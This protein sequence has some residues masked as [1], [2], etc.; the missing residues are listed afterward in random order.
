MKDKVRIG[1]CVA[2]LKYLKASL[3]VA[4]LKSRLNER[5]FLHGLYAFVVG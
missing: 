3:P 5:G 2:S 1:L 4:N